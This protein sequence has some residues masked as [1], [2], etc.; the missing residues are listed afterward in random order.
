MFCVVIFGNISSGIGRWKNLTP[1]HGWTSGSRPCFSASRKPY[2]KKRVIFADFSPWA[3]DGL[4]SLSFV[5]PWASHLNFSRKLIPLTISPWNPARIL[6]FFHTICIVVSLPPFLS[7]VLWKDWSLLTWTLSS[8]YTQWY[9]IIWIRILVQY[10]LLFLEWAV[11]PNI[12]TSIL[13]IT[14]KASFMFFC[15]RA[16]D[17]K[18]LTC[19]Q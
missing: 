4:A 10:W 12:S 7:S 16:D 9:N 8:L 6:C 2:R 18:T 17:E 11:V 1:F 13:S 3:L 15:H 5:L 14:K 19:F